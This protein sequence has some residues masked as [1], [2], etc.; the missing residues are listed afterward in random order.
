MKV[1]VTG[2]E[3]FA[4]EHLLSHL[5]EEGDETMATVFQKE[6]IPSM[7]EKGIDVV[8]QLDVTSLAACEAIVEDVKPEVVIHLAGLAFAPDS[9]K[10]FRMALDINVEGAY[11][12]LRAG[13]NLG[14]ENRVIIVSSSE[15]YGK[16]PAGELPAREDGPIRPN[17]NYSLSKAMAELVA[18]RFRE[19][20]RIQPIVIR[21]FNHIGPGQRNEFVASSFAYQ[22][23]EIDAGKRKPVMRVGNLSAERDFTDVRDIVRGYRLAAEKGQG[24]YNLC[25]GKAIPVQRILDTL[26]EVSGLDV[27]IEPD[28][29]R[30]RPSEVPI[31]FGSNEKAR[32]ELGWTPAIPLETSLRDVFTYWR[33][34][35]GIEKER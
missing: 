21:A 3:G 4:G 35:L 1:L 16:I 8:Q 5:L 18:A 25:S 33:E 2:A 19:G 28:P 9:E 23:A 7:K 13:H 29:E 27:T 30:M 24:M 15:V 11:N 34:H 14:F 6:D 12:I 10:N 31:L 17:H 20:S 22:L 32:Q 26:I